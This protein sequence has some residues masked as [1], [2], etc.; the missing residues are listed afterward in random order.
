MIVDPLYKENL[1]H[2]F[3]IA[4][5]WSEIDKIL[6]NLYDRNIQMRSQLE[7][8]AHMMCMRWKEI[9]IDRSSVHSAIMKLVSNCPRWHQKNVTDSSKH[10]RSL[11]YVYITAFSAQ[12]VTALRTACV[13]FLKA[14]AHPAAEFLSERQVGLGRGA[15]IPAWCTN[16]RKSQIL[17]KSSVPMAPKS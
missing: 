8:N 12:Y 4:C 2:F 15:Q 10:M 17:P 1:L 14:K 11:C 5:T 7:M 16:G 9:H 6:V 3:Q 13:L